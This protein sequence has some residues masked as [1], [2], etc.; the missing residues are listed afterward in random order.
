MAS[1]ES[2]E[3]IDTFFKSISDLHSVRKSLPG[4]FK[5]D[6]ARILQRAAKDIADHTG[7]FLHDIPFGEKP[8]DHT[9]E[10]MI[11]ASPTSLCYRNDKGQYPIHSAAT[12]CLIVSCVPSLVKEGLKHNLGGEGMRGGLLIEDPNDEHGSN[13]LEQLGR[14]WNRP[15]MHE[16]DKSFLDVM[17][18]LREAKL[19]TKND[20]RDHDVFYYVLVGCCRSRKQRFD[21]LYDW[22]PEGLKDYRY[23]NL[24]M[25]HALIKHKFKSSFVKILEVAFTNHKEGVDLLFQTDDD[26]ITACERAVDQFG[27]DETME[28]IGKHIP[29]GN[30]QFPILHH[31]AKH[32]PKLLN[33]FL[34]RYT[35]DGYSKDVDGRNLD[36]TILASGKTTF[37]NSGMYFIRTLSDEQ[38][39]EIDPVTKLYPFMVAASGETSDLSAVYVLMG[40]NPSLVRGG[41][42]VD[43]S[44]QSGRR[45]IK[46]KPTRSS[47]RAKR[48]KQE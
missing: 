27:S 4:G 42:I 11:S 38:V 29:I 31:V 2:E 43:G 9:L 39:G 46:R 45:L 10:T 21:F 8:D 13:P 23:E 16:F 1:I 20:M 37:Q 19:I 25:I 41:N 28:V 6:I 17:K 33:D 48:S 34:I 12:N 22:C 36:Q 30:P 40:R 7:K 15:R 24:P 32:A 3:L 26:G 5:Y 47:N 14:Q 18:K 44:E 35:S